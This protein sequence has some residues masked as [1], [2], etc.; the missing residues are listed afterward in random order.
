MPRAPVHTDDRRVPAADNATGNFL[1]ST[2]LV[3]KR[4]D[5]LVQQEC[6]N[7][8]QTFKSEFLLSRVSK[9]NLNIVGAPVS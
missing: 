7:V 6:R 5:Y 9:T 3:V 4:S 8:D 2:D 1:L